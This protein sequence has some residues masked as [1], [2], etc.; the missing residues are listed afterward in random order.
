MLNRRIL[1]LP[2]AVALNACALNATPRP[3]GSPTAD[4]P[5]ATVGLPPANTPTAAPD[6][7]GTAEPTP[8][9]QVLEPQLGLREAYAK[10]LEALG[11]LTFYSLDVG[12][13][14]Q[15]DGE[16]AVI[17]G[18]SLIRYSHDE[19]TA[20]REIALMLWPNDEQYV[21][22]MTVGQ[23]LVDG[24]AVDV[25]EELDGLALR[26]PLP[27]PLEAGRVVELFAPFRIEVG[28][29]G[30]AAPRRFGLTEGLLIAPTFY[31]LIPPRVAGDWQLLAA[32]P[33]GDTTNSEIALYQMTIRA[34][35]GLAII[36]S[37]VEVSQT[38]RDGRQQVVFVSGPMR[39]VAFA[40][41][42]L[43]E[44][45]RS[46]DDISLRAWLLDTHQAEAETLLDAAQRQVELLS[47]WV[48]PYRYAE[49]DLVDAP[50]AFGGIEYPGL[51][52]LG[53][54][55]TAWM[56]EPIVHEVA[57]QWF[58]ALVGGDQL[59]EPWLDEA[60]ATYA[61]AMYYED[62]GGSGRAA[63][64]LSDLRSLVRTQA[65]P[66]VPIGLP[67]G[68]Y[69]SESEYAIIVYFKGAL[70]FDALRHRLG[71]AS[72]ETFL[73]SYY[74]RGLYTIADSNL[75]LSAAED[76]CGC[77]LESMFDLWVYEGGLVSELE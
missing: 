38:E 29:F 46:V 60:A 74:A 69:A 57:H 73:Q 77:D 37:G 66:G 33:G 62:I 10:D 75:F 71:E 24:R 1:I 41:G 47:E 6:P 72:F 12:V 19:R 22:E 2:L 56:I 43:Q 27:R 65:D 50:G 26:V 54:I 13:T 61:T 21:A 23:V 63:G 16:S 48:G 11:P 42:P 32:P 25:T 30:P 15:P 4:V 18:S 39:D 55:G 36:A 44:Y 31:P 34:E 28:S 58:Y 49:L 14:I 40:V 45:T 7:T 76:A 20:L 52:Y 9:L 68:A 59:L 70:F 35:P 53:T 17:E 8:A 64:Y 5:P 67:V 51:V 3:A